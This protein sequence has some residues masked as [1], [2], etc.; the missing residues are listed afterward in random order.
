MPNN[1]GCILSI[2]SKRAVVLVSLSRNVPCV[3]SF[4]VLVLRTS[5]FPRFPFPLSLVFLL[6]LVR[7]HSFPHLRSSRS[8]LSPFL[9]LSLL[10]ALFTFAPL[11]PVLLVPFPWTF[12]C[13]CSIVW[14]MYLCIYVCVCVCVYMYVYVTAPSTYVRRLSARVSD[15][16]PMARHGCMRVRVRVCVYIRLNN[17]VSKKCA[18]LLFD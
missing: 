17:R 8:N 11:S 9:P 7:L 3:F 15:I 1:N 12:T 14:C 6:S 2:Y 5:S 10:T 4:S 13:T 16:G 18:V